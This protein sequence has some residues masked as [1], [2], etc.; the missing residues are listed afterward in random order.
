MASSCHSIAPS[1]SSGSE[2]G[3]QQKN[4]NSLTPISMRDLPLALIVTSRSPLRARA[5]GEGAVLQ[6]PLADVSGD[7]L[8]TIRQQVEVLSFTRSLRTTDAGTE[9][10]PLHG[11]LE[12]LTSRLA[13]G[14]TKRASAVS[15]LYIRSSGV[16]PR[17]IRDAANTPTPMNST[18]I[19]EPPRVA[20]AIAHVFAERQSKRLSPADCPIGRLLRT[21]H[22]Q[23]CALFVG[24]PS[25][26][27][28]R[29]LTHQSRTR[30][31]SA[32]ASKCPLRTITRDLHATRQR[33]QGTDVRFRRSPQRSPRTPPLQRRQR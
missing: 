9:W 30:R 19:S 13:G 11:D 4:P 23:I 18:P 3:S 14:V 29:R 33:R 2:P 17:P 7:D 10:S 1:G 28:S 6:P 32:A 15:E 25:A 24:R 5:V 31:S 12:R 16:G 21:P 26:T 22:R 8:E 20:R 27:I